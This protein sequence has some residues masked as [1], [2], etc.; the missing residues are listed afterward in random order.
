M[1]NKFFIII[2]FVIFI[3]QI[4]L[5]TFAGNAFSVYSNYGLT[6]KQWLISVGFGSISLLVNFLLKLIKINENE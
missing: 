4:L 6:V 1:S 2:V 5:I 3:L